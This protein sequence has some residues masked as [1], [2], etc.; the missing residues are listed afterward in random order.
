MKT[1]AENLCVDTV[2]ESSRTSKYAAVLS[3]ESPTTSLAE[4]NFERG[5]LKKV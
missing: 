1:F 5:L 4:A 2:L 3:S